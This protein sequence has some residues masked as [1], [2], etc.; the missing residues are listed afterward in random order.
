M[1]LSA[2]ND[3]ALG[4]R[5]I[6]TESSLN[7]METVLSGSAAFYFVRGTRSL[8]NYLVPIRQDKQAKEEGGKGG[9]Q[10]ELNKS[11]RGHLVALAVAALPQALPEAPAGVSPSHI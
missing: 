4:A 9:R 5:D 8:C 7:V 10:A 3:A 11:K 1:L 6:A 2:I